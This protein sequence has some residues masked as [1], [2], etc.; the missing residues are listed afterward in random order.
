MN[1]PER[2][3]MRDC[4]AREKWRKKA[5]LKSRTVTDRN[6]RDHR[7]EAAIAAPVWRSGKNNAESMFNGNAV[8]SHGF[9]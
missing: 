4:R 3:L 6:I 5:D 2:L 9:V 7:P 8:A 1:W